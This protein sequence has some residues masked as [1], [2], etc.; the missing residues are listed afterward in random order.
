MGERVGDLLRG[1][2]EWMTAYAADLAVTVPL[3]RYRWNWEAIATPTGQLRKLRDFCLIVQV[4]TRTW[5]TTER[6]IQA[7]AR[8]R[9]LSS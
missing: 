3:P 1:Q 9:R 7:I 2:A 8:L 5:K 4:D 6:L